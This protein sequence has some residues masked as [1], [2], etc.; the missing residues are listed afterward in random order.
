MIQFKALRPR[1][2]PAWLDMASENAAHRIAVERDQD[3]ERRE[4][5]FLN[6]RDTNSWFNMAFVALLSNK[7]GVSVVPS[8]Y[9]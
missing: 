9:S 2:L 8:S 4:G 1:F 3:G 5:V 6:R 7:M